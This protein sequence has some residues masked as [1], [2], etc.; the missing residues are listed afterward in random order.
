[1]KDGSIHGNSRSVT[2]AD[3]TRV[4]VGSSGDPEASTATGK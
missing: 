3:G 2:L 4:F 1:M